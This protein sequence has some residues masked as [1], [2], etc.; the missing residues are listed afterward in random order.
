MKLVGLTGGI[1]SGKSTVAGLL[2]EHGAVVI[3]ADAIVH[4]LQAKGTPLLAEIAR[5]FG[6][7]ILA[8]DGSL[9]R[10]ALGAI[11][12]RDEAA[13]TRLGQIVHPK[14]GA[15]MVRRIE[16]ARE[17][18]HSLVVLD[19]PLLLEGRKAGRAA[20][21]YHAVVVVWVPTEVQVERTVSRDDCSEEEA[22]RR[23]AAQ[24]S[25]DEKRELAD[26]VIDNSGGLEATRARVEELVADLLREDTAAGAVPVERVER[27]PAEG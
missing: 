6:P 4:E 27:E 21:P 15:E 24:M 20:V 22:R 12:F 19:V 1:G 7:E 10:E 14:V 23:I 3:D 17:A 13:R 26:H 5:A 16:A 11:V 9:D 25:L 8:E 18:G 2:A